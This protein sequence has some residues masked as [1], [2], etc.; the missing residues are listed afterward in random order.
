LTLERSR[1]WPALSVCIIEEAFAHH[2]FA[3]FA[4]NV[5]GQVPLASQRRRR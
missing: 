5:F 1:S 3:E 2:S 4:S